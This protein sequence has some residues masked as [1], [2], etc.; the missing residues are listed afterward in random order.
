MSDKVKLAVIDED[1][2][3]RSLK[4]HD[5]SA[6]GNKITVVSGGEGHFMPSFDNDSFLEFKQPWY[7]GGGWER[8]YFAK[9]RAKACIDFKAEKVYGPDPE[10]MK[11][12]VGSTLLSEIGKE[13]TVFPVWILYVLLLATIGIALKVFGVIV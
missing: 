8:I 2:K 9:K 11:R 6:T 12:A 5:V 7:K 1:L 13:R 3:I 4:K 10:E